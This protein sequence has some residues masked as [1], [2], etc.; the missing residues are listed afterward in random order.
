MS[1][2]ATNILFGGDFFDP[3]LLQYFLRARYYLPRLGRFL[4]ADS[5]PAGCD[6]PR[7]LNRFTYAFQDPV[8]LSDPL[9]NYPVTN[10]Q[11]TFVHTYLTRGQFHFMPVPGRQ[12][13]GNTAI[14]TIVQELTG[15]V[16]PRTLPYTRRPDFVE[17][18]NTVNPRE[19]DVYELRHI[20][21]DN[22]DAD[23]NWANV[24]AGA[25]TD[26]TRYRDELQRQLPS[27]AWGLGTTLW[28]G[29]KAWPTAVIP[30]IP[31]DRVLTTFA[32]GPGVFLYDFVPRT[33]EES[34]VRVFTRNLA[35][36]GTAVAALAV[37][38]AIDMIRTKLAINALRAW[39]PWAVAA[40]N[41]VE[42]VADAAVGLLD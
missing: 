24:A 20:D 15:V 29:V 28:P 14:R 4:S 16:L 22:P 10:T 41:E 21:L 42:A 7:S 5:F 2:P 11:G 39:A 33:E 25:A 35:Q 17:V 18:W 1:A 12:R 37:G 32:A 13:F 3:T 6:D 40:G 30:G 27:F 8:N 19:G 23:A 38:V 26:A 34:W 31:S 36:Y 9:G